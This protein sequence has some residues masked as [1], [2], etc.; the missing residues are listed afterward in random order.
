MQLK[1]P[2]RTGSWHQ[3]LLNLSTEVGDFLKELVIWASPPDGAVLARTPP[4]LQLYC[5][6]QSDA[7]SYFAACFR[8]ISVKVKFLRNIQS[9]TLH[10]RVI[11]NS[12]CTNL[13]FAMPFRQVAVSVFPN[14][15]LFSLQQG[16]MHYFQ[17]HYSPQPLVRARRNH[18]LPAHQYQGSFQRTDLARPSQILQSTMYSLPPIWW[19]ATLFACHSFA[20]VV[21]LH[22]IQISAYALLPTT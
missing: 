2:E 11:Q 14:F 13:L 8:V 6:M 21:L 20:R 22:T 17:I 16:I 19:K 10:N 3:N 15:L 9:I 18:V 1:R 4:L 7:V 12:I 5:S